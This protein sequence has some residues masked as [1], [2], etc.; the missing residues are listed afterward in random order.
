MATGA[1]TPIDKH[2]DA[3][4]AFK[5]SYRVKSEGDLRRVVGWLVDWLKG[6]N[7]SAYL[8]D[9]DRKLAGTFIDGPLVRNRGRK[10]AGAYLGFLREY[11]K[12]L[13]QRG[14]VEE[15]PWAGQEIAPEPRRRAG[16]DDGGKRPFTDDEINKLVYGPATGYL[17]DL[18]RVA[19]LTGMRI[20]EICQLQVKDCSGGWLQ[21]HAGKTA[22][23]RRK[24]PIHPDLKALIAARTDKRDGAEYLFGELP[25]VPDSRDTRSD[26]ASKQFTR[27][28]RKAQVDERPNGKAK[29]N[30][31]F[32]S[33][34]RWF[35][36]QARDAMATSKHRYGL[37]VIA[38]IVGHDDKEV[39]NLLAL[40]ASHY[41]GEAAEADKKACVAAVKLPSIVK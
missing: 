14:H 9:F 30:V 26:P 28:R 39:K 41:P 35:I 11:W 33:F 29:S 37:W 13:K 10:K 19:A 23:A 18:M 40:T 36:R 20:E 5:G 34:R 24:I 16:D 8:E 17:P 3:F 12:W 27:Y 25:E 21:V 22:A 6:R 38:D 32:H 31:D 2:L 4:I 7:N 1:S 15:S